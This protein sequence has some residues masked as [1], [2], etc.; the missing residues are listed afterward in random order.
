MKRRLSRSTLSKGDRTRQ[1]ILSE[2]ATL[3]NQK[4][5]E[6]TSLSELMGVTGLEK[7]GLYRHFSSKEHLAAEAFDFAWD[8]ACENRFAGLDEIP[9][10]VDRLKRFI[11]NFVEHRPTLPG[12]CPV[13]NTAIDTDDGNLRL[14]NRVRQALQQWVSLLKDTI[15][16]G[17]RKMEI[18]SK[19]DATGLA[20]LI[21]SS[22]EGALAITRLQRDQQALR[23][24]RAYLEQYLE[25]EVREGSQVPVKRNIGDDRR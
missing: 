5:F 25:S 18:R 15:E 19:T 13:F 16:I 2:A 8:R 4:G 3:F 6:G 14:R 17:I 21:I 24:T 1:R 11:S 12:G 20:L 7:G 23:A 22:L 9:N 10:S